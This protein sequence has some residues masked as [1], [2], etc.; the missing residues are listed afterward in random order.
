L[1][2]STLIKWYRETFRKLAKWGRNKEESLKRMERDSI[3]DE[4]ALARNGPRLVEFIKNRRFQGAGSSTAGND[5]VWIGVVLRAAKNVDRKPVR[6]EIVDEA[7]E[8]CRELRLIGKSTGAPDDRLTLSWV[9]WT[10][11]FNFVT[12]VPTFQCLISGIS[13]SLRAAAKMKY[14]ACC[15]KTTTRRLVRGWC[16][17][18]NIPNIKTAIIAD[19]DTP[20]RVGISFNGNRSPMRGFFPTNPGVFVRP[21]PEAIN[22]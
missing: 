13:P 10:A 8:A 4:D 16:A 5:L 17:M 20:R 7:R 18:P 22:C 9:P 3:A 2:L 14:A 21:S 11:I 19:F 12:S 15:G 1:K 6:P